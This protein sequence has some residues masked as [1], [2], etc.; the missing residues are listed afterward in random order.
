M[1]IFVIT[2]FHDVLLRWLNVFFLNVK[3]LPYSRQ[4]SY[5]YKENTLS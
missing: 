2:Y 5:D 3:N 1:C 4:Y